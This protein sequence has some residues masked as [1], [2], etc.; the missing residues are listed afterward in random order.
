MKKDVIKTLFKSEVKY[1]SEY[2]YYEFFSFGGFKFKAYVCFRNGSTA[3]SCT[4][5]VM[6]K[7]GDFSVVAN[8]D[9][10]GHT[11]ASYV[12]NNRFEANREALICKFK[13]FVKAVYNE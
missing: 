11:P 8:A 9:T 7:D 4:L 12:D 13:N 5:S 1:R 6:T 10:V 2:Q 3:K